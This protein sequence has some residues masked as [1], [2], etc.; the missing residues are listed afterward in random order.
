[1][2]EKLKVKKPILLKLNKNYFITENNS[3]IKNLNFDCQGFGAVL[4]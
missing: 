4:V 2:I 1:M 3:L